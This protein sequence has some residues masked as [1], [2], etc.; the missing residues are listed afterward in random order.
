MSDLLNRITVDPNICNGK[1]AFRNTR[2][3]VQTVLDFLAA[4]DDKADIVKAY[5]DLTQNDVRTAL[6]YA[7]R[8]LENN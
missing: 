4:G 7:S 2:I 1:P 5:P 3:T 8:L 6:E